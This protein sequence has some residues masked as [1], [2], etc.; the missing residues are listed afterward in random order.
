M[1]ADESRPLSG[2]RA[3]PV[4][5][6][7]LPAGLARDLR[8]AVYRLYAEA[9]R[10]QLAELARKIAEDNDLPGSPG[11]DLIGKII[12]GDGLAGQQDT[13]TVATVLAW[14]AG[15]RDVAHV[16]EQV[17]QLWIAA[18]TAEPSA[19]TY[20]RLGWPIGECD[21]LVLGV[22]P[23]I[24][25]PW[26]VTADV[27]PRYMPRAHDGR[28][29]ELV[30]GMLADGRSRLVT[31]VGG[32]STGK[33]RTG[34]ELAQYLKNQR[35][36]RW[37]LWH[38]FDPTRPQ[39]A[40]ANLANAGP[41]TIV[42][43]NEAQDYLM[44][45]DTALGER[46]AAGL[47][48][49]LTEPSRGP[50]LVLSTMWTD[51]WNTLTSR[52]SEP[53]ADVYGQVRE[54]L[55]LSV[56]VD[57]GDTFTPAELAGL[58]GPGVDV[59]LRYAAKQ[60][61]SGRIT[62]YLAGA[63][64]LEDRY[65]TAPPAARAI[66]QVAID[67]RRLGY[68]VALPHALLEQAAPGYLTDHDWDACGDDWLEQALAYTAQPCKGARSPLT[69]IRPRHGEP[70]S[71]GGQ[72]CYRLADYL[73]QLGRTERA[74]VY[75][76]DSLWQA[77][78][79]TD[80]DPAATVD[81]VV[82]RRLGNQAGSR[83]RLQEA[84]RLYLKAA[85]LGDADA[86]TSIAGVLEGAGE[87]V[88]AERLYQLALDGGSVSAAVAL[89]QRCERAGNL[90]D[91]MVLYQRAA[92]RGDGASLLR[93]A[94]LCRNAGD[95]T[96]AEA[97]CRQAVD[98][99]VSGGLLALAGIRDRL[100]DD[101]ACEAL[102]E[103]GA[104]AGETFALQFLVHRRVM[105]EDLAGAES[106]CRTYTAR[107]SSEAWMVWAGLRE[108]CDDFMGAEAYYR[109]AAIY[110]M[111]DAV[112]ALARMHAEIGDVDGATNL[113]RQAVDLG[114]GKAWR[115]L[116]RLMLDAGDMAGVEEVCREAAHRGQPHLLFWLAGLREGSGDDVGADEL[117]L[118]AADHGDM[119]ALHELAEVR[120]EA[121]DPAGAMA[122]YL[123]AVDLGDR[124]AGF[125]WAR[126]LTAIGDGR[127]AQQLTRFGLTGDG[128]FATGLD[129]GP[130]ND[131]LPNGTG[132]GLRRTDCR[133]CSEMS[134]RDPGCRP[135]DQ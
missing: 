100:G 51:Y 49:L 68:P 7:P 122:M 67:A 74:S 92:T 125:A 131:L 57:L 105:R 76:P 96:G 88:G 95:L 82:L 30:D 80:I 29:R 101:A 79:T 13:V 23:A 129:L 17:R 56:K 85:D 19:T 110:G 32:S 135:L 31:L 27:L 60:A 16:A 64:A 45:P 134:D 24:Q 66:L 72:P 77:F 54:L 46:I 38:P 109:Q 121:G 40:L 132:C 111:P 71:A 123:R 94:D 41:E 39:A 59:R 90:D 104:D 52:P 42:W 22:H 130:F 106:L 120:V 18:A 4:E 81:P 55:A 47:R 118:L 69:R 9:D 84:I 25:V 33:T 78:S 114:S 28:L 36:G 1:S 6:K 34:W 10:P 43:L 44:P 99:R 97:L 89:A 20:D 87:T 5:K 86:L 119:D 112:I 21:P 128:R 133:L 15:C 65:R 62:Q 115:P 35:P 48:T 73:E 8:D 108:R 70:P 107:G 126:L 12:S 14:A 98:R 113:Y 93:A 37:R 50:V 103:Q 124:G 2:R 116:A 61:E 127:S 75:P 26:E 83:L 63:P 53:G 3:R 91:A 58:V 11:K 102:L 117:R